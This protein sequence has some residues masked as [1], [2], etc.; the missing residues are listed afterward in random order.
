MSLSTLLN[1]PELRPFLPLLYV[2]WAD[3]DLSEAERSLLQARITAQPWLKPRLREALG[4]WL[5]PKTPPGADALARL[6]RS[7]DEAAPS[8]SPDARRS[9]T[10]LAEAMGSVDVTHDRATLDALRTVE[11]MLSTDAL[12]SPAVHADATPPRPRFSAGALQAVL[13]GRFAD[14][15]NR[16]RA[17]LAEPAHRAMYGVPKEAHRDVVFSWLKGLSDRGLGALAYPGV[18]STADSLGPFLA[19]FETLGSGDLS[20]LVKFGVQF[21]LWGGS[22]FFLG[23][24]EQRTKW[25]PQVASLELPGCFAM[26]EVGHGSNVADLETVARYDAAKGELVIHT[27]TESARKDWAGNAALHAKMAT[28]FA[29]LEVDGVRHGVHAVVVPIRGD[30]GTVLPGVR[31]GDCGHKLGLN[32]V[33]NGRLWFDEVRVPAGN[34]LGRYARITPEGR[35]ESPIESPSKRFFTML[36]TLVGGR[37]AVA[38]GGLSASKLGLT[39]A[40]R[41]ATQRRQFG[42]TSEPETLLLDYPTHQRRLLPF[43]AATYAFHFAIDAARDEFLALPPDAD[44]REVEATVAGIKAAA[45]WHA[46]ATLQ[47]CR[48]ACGGQGYLAVNRLADARADADIFTTFEGD[49]TVLLQLVAKSLLTG[50]RQQFTRGG[51]SGLVRYLLQRAKTVVTEKNPVSARMTD[52]TALRSAEVQLAA[53]SYREQTLLASAAQRLKKRLDAKVE[54]TRAFLDVQEHLVALAHAHVERRVLEAFEAGVRRATGD[55]ARALS[56]LRE[57]HGLC[58]LERHLGWFLEDGVFEAPRARAVR[59]LIPSLLAEV[60]VDAVG[61]VDAFGIPDVCL[62]APIAFNDPAHPRW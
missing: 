11:A 23:T 2:A 49:N 1:E 51:A 9:L 32:G 39:I 41:Y 37:I 56:R 22:V 10:A 42:P 55:E 52:Q 48:E 6:K 35:Y 60:R 3:G 21:G 43:L 18:T 26:S 62:A 53:L 44:T 50:F 12:A 20:L 13:D 25:L 38:S 8:L 33:D 61:L 4:A 31:I 7:L 34:L 14:A 57:L 27:P 29:Q 58:T 46:S 24:D 40:I 17:F 5:D 19:V 59:K 47:A 16:A 15:R 36:G 45:T 30:D 54:P 28:V